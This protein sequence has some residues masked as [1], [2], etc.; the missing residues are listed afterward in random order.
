[1]E[2]YTVCD[3]VSFTSLSL[4]IIHVVAC[5]STLFLL[6]AEQYSTLYTYH[7]V[8]SC[9]L[10]F[11]YCDLTVLPFDKFIITR[12]ILGSSYKNIVGQATF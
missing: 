7:H 2:L 9:S 8:F 4:S 5:I 11:G 10:P 12:M 3:V 1:M 6:I